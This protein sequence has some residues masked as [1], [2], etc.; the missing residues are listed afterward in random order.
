MN[1]QLPVWFYAV[2]PAALLFSSIM[3]VVVDWIVER[4]EKRRSAEKR[5]AWLHL[6]QH[7]QCRC[8]TLADVENEDGLWASDE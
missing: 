7:V 4:Q 2:L 5:Y 3:A 6:P 8:W 1:G